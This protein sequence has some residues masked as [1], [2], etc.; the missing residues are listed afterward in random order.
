MVRDKDKILLLVLGR[1]AIQLDMANACS[2]SKN[3]GDNRAFEG[4]EGLDANLGLQYLAVNK[5]EDILVLVLEKSKRDYEQ[6]L[7]THQVEDLQLEAKAL[8]LADAKG[9]ESTVMVE[10]DKGDMIDTMD[11]LSLRVIET[12]KAKSGEKTSKVS[13]TLGKESTVMVEMDKGDMID[14]VDALSLRVM[15]SKFVLARSNSSAIEPKAPMARVKL[16]A[17][18]IVKAKSGRKTSKVLK[19]TGNV[20]LSLTPKI[21]AERL[22]ETK[23]MLRDF[24]PR[25]WKELRDLE[26][27]LWRIDGCPQWSEYRYH[28]LKE[29]VLV[30][31]CQQRVVDLYDTNNI[32]TGAEHQKAMAAGKKPEIPNPK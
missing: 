22:G 31:I 21:N 27:K 2:A 11:A 9:K 26:E 18:E 3:R 19:T 30:E 7:Q 13:K 28:I 20:A 16:Q 32:M 1:G 5:K 8:S 24:H 15:I 29:G 14:T 23:T 6:Q 10:M 4:R 17:M 25:L 12:V